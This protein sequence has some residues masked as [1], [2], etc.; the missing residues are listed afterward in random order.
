[1]TGLKTGIIWT[2][3]QVQKRD[4]FMI[5]EYIFM[6]RE[7]EYLKWQHSQEIQDI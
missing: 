4:I 5:E 2:K 6:K 1:M 3:N 7:T